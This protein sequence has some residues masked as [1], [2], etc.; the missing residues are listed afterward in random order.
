[1]FFLELPPTRSSR[2]EA[3]GRIIKIA[4]NL[5]SFINLTYINVK[6]CI[7]DVSEYGNFSGFFE[8][9]V[10]KRHSEHY[11]KNKIQKSYCLF[12]KYFNI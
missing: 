4:K 2:S 3:T 1:M 10:E 5:T 9:L 11:I 12:A 7:V 8:F 6:I